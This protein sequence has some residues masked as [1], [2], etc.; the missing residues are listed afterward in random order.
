MHE[1]GHIKGIRRLILQNAL[2]ENKV[3][4]TESGLLLQM[5]EVLLKFA[6]VRRGRKGKF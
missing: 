2:C 1:A 5:S 4:Q 3:L 6:K